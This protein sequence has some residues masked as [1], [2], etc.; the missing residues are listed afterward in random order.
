MDARDAVATVRTLRTSARSVSTSN[1]SIRSRRIDV[2]S[3]DEAS[4][5]L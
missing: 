5:L 2:I 1:F 3:S 4:S